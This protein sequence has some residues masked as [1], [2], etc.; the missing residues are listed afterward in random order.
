MPG[1]RKVVVTKLIG[2]KDKVPRLQTA[3]A[4]IEMAPPVVGKCYEV[5][6]ND[7]HLFLRTSLLSKISDGYIHTRNSVYKVKVLNRGGEFNQGKR[8]GSDY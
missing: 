6:L 7:G 3:L 2:S 4:G 8:I 1:H 5:K